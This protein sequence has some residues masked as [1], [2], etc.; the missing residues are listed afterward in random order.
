MWGMGADRAKGQY[1]RLLRAFLRRPVDLR[2]ETEAAWVRAYP[3]RTRSVGFW[4]RAWRNNSSS[5]GRRS[6]VRRWNGCALE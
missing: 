4:N 6:C 5:G 3:M 2:R 1:V